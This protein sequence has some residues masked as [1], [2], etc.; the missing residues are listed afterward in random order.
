MTTPSGGYRNLLVY[1]LAVIIYDLNMKFVNR[2]LSDTGKGLPTRRTQ[3]QMIQGARSGKQ[4]IVEGSL[5]KSSKLNI[6]LNSVARSSFGE[7]G[8]DYHDFLRTGGFKVWDKDDPRVLKI[9]GIRINMSNRTNS[10]NLYLYWTHD[11][12]LFA[13]LM[14]TLISLECY[15]LDNLLRALDKKFL[16]EGGYT[17][18][19]YRRRQEYRRNK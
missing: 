3:D 5:E 10:T 4:C 12:E 19:L 2:Y 6:N 17:E 8:E 9:R 14:I 16:E 11:A 7:L 18:N 15:L 13:N 1:Q